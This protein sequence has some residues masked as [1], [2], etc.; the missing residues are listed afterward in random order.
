MTTTTKAIIWIVVIALVL[1]GG[2]FA[3]F[4]TPSSPADTLGNETD[5]DVVICTMDARQCPD[6]SFVGRTGPNC[7]FVCPDGNAPSEAGV[8]IIDGNVEADG[9][10]TTFPADEEK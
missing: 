6:G 2:Y 5:A 1:V 7:E 10:V 8:P 4:A 9:T 3:F